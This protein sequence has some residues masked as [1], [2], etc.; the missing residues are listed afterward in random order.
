M[1]LRRPR[2]FTLIELLVVVA[3]IALLIGILLPV[4]SSAQRAARLTRCAANLQQFGVA[5][6]AY[7]ADNDGQIWAFTWR[8]FHQNS[9]YSDLNGSRNTFVA[10][11][12]QATDIIRRELFEDLPDVARRTQW[13]APVWY[14]HLTILRYLGQGYSYEAVICPSDKGKLDDAVDPKAFRA[15]EPSIKWHWSFKSSYSPVPAAYDPNPR[16]GGV[17]QADP[18][19]QLG[20]PCLVGGPPAD[21]GSAPRRQD[22]RRAH[23]QRRLRRTESPPVRP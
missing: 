22:R 13:L 17:A 1:R 9:R 20:F 19:Q 4:L 18:V 2:A 15:N 11:G 8:K 6:G 3:V 23:A 14:S 21:R 7:A 5:T 16:L 12:D 10:V